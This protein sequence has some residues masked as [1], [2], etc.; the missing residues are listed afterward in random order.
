MLR[1]EEPVHRPRPHRRAIQP[2]GD[3]P[4]ATRL[5][6]PTTRASTRRCRPH[7]E[8]NMPRHMTRRT[9]SARSLPRRADGI[10]REGAAARQHCRHLRRPFR[11]GNRDTGWGCEVGNRTGTGADPAGANSAVDRKRGTGA[12]RRTPCSGHT[13]ARARSHAARDGRCAHAMQTEPAAADVDELPVQ[14][15][16][17]GTVVSIGTDLFH[18]GPQAGWPC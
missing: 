1:G 10:G 12:S 2:Q 15:A 7:L 5:A 13:T 16:V 11:F 18:A 14:E 8:R 4:P 9:R 3:P 17:H 6:P